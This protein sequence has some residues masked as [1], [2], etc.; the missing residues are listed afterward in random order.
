MRTRTRIASALA[1]AGLAIG[2]TATAAQAN[3]QYG[4]TA[5]YGLGHLHAT[6]TLINYGS[7]I[8]TADY[9]SA[10]GYYHESVTLASDRD[11]HFKQMTLTGGNTKYTNPSQW[12]SSTNPLSFSTH[13]IKVT[14]TALGGGIVTSCTI[15]AGV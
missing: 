13:Y 9:V 15:K 6:A 7:G 10:T 11:W 2:L 14:W 5:P 1:A 8:G 12:G 4:C 3:A